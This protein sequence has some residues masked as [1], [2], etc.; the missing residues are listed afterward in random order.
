MGAMYFESHPIVGILSVLVMLAGTFMVL[1]APRLS[2][3]PTGSYRRLALSYF[4]ITRVGLFLAIFVIIGHPAGCDKHYWSLHGTSALDGLLPYI[5]YPSEYG[6]LFCYLLAPAFLWLND[7][8]APVVVFIFF[9]F[10]TFLFLHRVTGDWDADRRIA[11]IYLLTPISW[12]VVVRY[13]QDESIAAFFLVLL[14]V[15]A[16]RGRDSSVSVAAGIGA[17]ATKVLFIPLA[18]P[19]LL[20]RPRRFRVLLIAG[21]VLGAFYLPFAIRGGNIIE[22]LPPGGYHGGISLWA[23]SPSVLV[24]LGWRATLGS[25]LL[26]ISALVLVTVKGRTMGVVNSVLLV[27]SALMLASPKAWPWYAL[28][29]L[30]LLSMRVAGSAHQREI[31]FF[32]VYGFCIVFYFFAVTATKE[33]NFLPSPALRYMTLGYL[34]AY[35]LFLF[36]TSIRSLAGGRLVPGKE[37]R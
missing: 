28:L 36:V 35:H 18:L 3:L 19:I 2:R 6:P 37:P 30:P 21:A 14:M 7:I 24:D 15:L 26:I 25:A 29:A 5:D 4:L 11:S 8:L 16:R 13:G 22:W 9:D 12:F 20:A 27:F 33:F 17:A 10:L 32:S 1:L 34:A 31:A 23:F